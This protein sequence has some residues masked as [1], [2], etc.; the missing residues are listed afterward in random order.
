MNVGKRIAGIV[1]LPGLM[2]IAA[3]VWA[4]TT[5]QSVG[6]LTRDVASIA[7]VHPLVGALSNVGMILWASAAAICVFSAGVVRGGEGHGEAWFLFSSGGISFVVLL[8]DMFLIHEDLAGRYLG[9]GQVQIL[10]AYGTIILAYL[11]V[12]RQRILGTSYPLLLLSI[13]FFVVSVALDQ[14]GF[15]LGNWHLLWEDG[16]KFVGQFL[17]L[18]Y[19][20]YT[21]HALLIGKI[22]STGGDSRRTL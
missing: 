4:A 6:L 14:V 2:L 13:L 18:G 12:F 11:I 9:M 7:Q 10:G 1:L 19:F 17:W 21:S 16:A 8:D 3:G 20:A 22:K 5:G 15:H